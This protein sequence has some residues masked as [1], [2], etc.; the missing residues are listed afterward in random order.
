MIS[1]LLWMIF[2]VAGFFFGA[3]CFSLEIVFHQIPDTKKPAIKAGFSIPA[4]PVRQP[5][6]RSIF[7]GA[8]RGNRTLI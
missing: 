1:I 5:N 3:K 4:S 2:R 6:A 8:G 7:G